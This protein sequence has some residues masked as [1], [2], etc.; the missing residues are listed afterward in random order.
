MI[1]ES[2][3]EREARTHTRTY[4]HTHTSHPHGCTDAHG[5]HLGDEEVVNLAEAK[6][7]EHARMQERAQQVRLP[8]E[9]LH[10]V[11]VVAHVVLYVHVCA[12]VCV[13]AR[14]R[15]HVCV[16]VP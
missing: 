14:V 13:R 5:T 15:V 9:F 11:L 4:T 3:R 2:A 16:D 7:A 10:L 1:R 12:C 6:D 8:L